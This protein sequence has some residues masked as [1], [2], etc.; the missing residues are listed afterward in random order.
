[1]RVLWPSHPRLKQRN[2]ASVQTIGI[3]DFDIVGPVVEEVAAMIY[4]FAES[5]E[6][7]I[8]DPLF[9]RFHLS[10]KR[11]AIGGIVG[12]TLPEAFVFSCAR[13]PANCVVAHH[14]SCANVMRERTRTCGA[15]G[16]YAVAVP[17]VKCTLDAFVGRSSE[18]QVFYICEI[19][20]R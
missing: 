13:A 2:E 15:G 16:A 11:L 9:E 4:V 6:A 17:R 20:R 3:L 8:G 10:L 14:V 7:R 18:A 19:N 1:M 5:H 12:M